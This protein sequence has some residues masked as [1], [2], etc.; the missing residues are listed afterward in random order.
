MCISLA[1]GGTTMRYVLGHNH[2]S[3]MASRHK[4]RKTASRSDDVGA[5]K[6]VSIH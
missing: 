1:D 3:K 5:R 4:T 6:A 2:L